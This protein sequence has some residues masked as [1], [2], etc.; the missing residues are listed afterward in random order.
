[1]SLIE[2][3]KYNKKDCVNEFVRDLIQG[4]GVENFR[5]YSLNGELDKYHIR[6]MAWKIFME[7][8]P[9]TETLEQWVETIDNLRKEYK[10]KAKTILKTQKFKGDPLSGMAMTNSDNS[11]WKTYYADNDTKKLINL[12]LDRTFQE[13]EIFHQAKIK[14]SL[15]DILFMWNKENLDVGYQQGMN[16]I[17]A[18]TFL[19]LYPCY[20]KNTKK[21]GKDEILK[22]SSEQ[23]SAIQNAEDIYDFFH[24]E[25]ELYSDLFYCF[26][27]LMKRGLK[28]LFQTIKGNEKLVDYK[29]YELFHNQLEQD[30]TDDMQNPLS[31]R[32]TLIIKEKLKS[33][34][35]D[36]YQHFK[37]IGLNCGIFLQRWLKCMFDREFE[38]KDIFIIWDAI[39]ATPDAQN[40]YGLVFLDYIAISM[41]LRIR[42]TLLDSDQNECFTTLFKYPT[43]ENM[44]EL[45]IFSNNLQIA[46]EEMISGKRSAFLDRLLGKA[47]VITNNKNNNTP[48]MQNNFSGNMSFFPEGYNSNF[49]QGNNDNIKENKGFFK[50]AFS[51]VGGF[52]SNMKHKIEKKIDQ[53]FGQHNDNNN[54]NNNNYNYTNN[55]YNNN[56]VILG[57]IN[58]IVNMNMNNMGYI[59][60]VSNMTNFNQINSLNDCSQRIENLFNKYSTYFSTEDANEYKAIIQYLNNY[61]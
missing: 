29:K 55:N 10:K 57:E 24:D 53:K 36:L 54:N 39:F 9:E 50:N 1:M 61:K 43:I 21:L 11:T 17:L 4:N 30:S 14:S 33:I 8:L 51:S 41:I 7:V 18:V 32:C 3:K 42:K 34:D 52:F 28:E 59:N 40:G 44:A 22:I 47:P 37:K 58:P 35:P 45:V 20:F 25:D 26:T 12:D 23:I 56:G 2:T 16:D 6:G 15:A 19:G 38:L 48:V 46:V 13:L 27:K 5:K 60:N 49:I 31:I